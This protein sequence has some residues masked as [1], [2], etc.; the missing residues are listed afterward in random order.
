MGS[1][2]YKRG[3]SFILFMRKEKEC[4]VAGSDEDAMLVEFQ[5]SYLHFSLV[6]ILLTGFDPIS[7]TA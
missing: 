4:L 5:K 7:A 3:Q 6:I 2:L 1:W